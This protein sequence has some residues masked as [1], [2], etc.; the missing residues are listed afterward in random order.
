MPTAH[1]KRL[2]SHSPVSDPAVPPEWDLL[3]AASSPALTQDGIAGLRF[4]LE[5]PVEWATLLGLADEHGTSSLV[6]QNLARISDAVPSQSLALLRERHER[7]IHKSLFLT[8][9]LI[10]ILDCLEALRIEVLPY[11][12]VVLSEMLYGDLASRQSGDIDLFVRRDD[13]SRIKLAVRGLGY[14]P[15]LTIP[16]AAA[17]DYIAAGYELTFDSPAGKNLLEL[18]W[19]LQPRFYAVDYDMDGL[20][21][22]AVSVSVAGR[23]MKTPSPE[24]LLLVLSVHAAKHVWGR[25]I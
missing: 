5:S 18:Q 12:G 8:R 10:R 11:K 2:S 19:A 25:L 24:D 23:P 4:L 15:R 17:R 1:T 13:V 16:A 20:F 21:R 3:L 22:R 14:V 6:Y 9:D 7:N